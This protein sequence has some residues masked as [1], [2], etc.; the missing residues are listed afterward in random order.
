MANEG[1]PSGLSASVGE[2]LR[3]KAE[4]ERQASAERASEASRQQRVE[5]QK[6]EEREV[7]LRHSAGARKPRPRQAYGD[8]PPNAWWW[9]A[10]AMLLVGFVS[11]VRGRRLLIGTLTLVL[12]ARIVA[13]ALRRAEE[14]RLLSSAGTR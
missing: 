14:E 9:S 1:D 13:A 10:V 8:T 2:Q 3:G 6:A 7:A 12:G 11:G 4:A 5:R